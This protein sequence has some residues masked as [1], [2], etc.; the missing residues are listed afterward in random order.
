MLS[1]LVYLIKKKN[2]IYNIDCYFKWLPAHLGSQ[3]RPGRPQKRTQRQLTGFLCTADVVRLEP[4][5]TKRY[6]SLQS[7]HDVLDLGH[8]QRKH[9]G[10]AHCARQRSLWHRLS[11]RQH[12]CDSRRRRLDADVRSEVAWA[13]DDIVRNRSGRRRG[14]AAA[15]AWVEQP[16][17]VIHCNI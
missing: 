16:G 3:R 12:F 9:Q 2:L 10:S 7:R 8:R 4:T 14:Q 5:R 15:Q 6:R 13:L 1:V 17:L 11:G